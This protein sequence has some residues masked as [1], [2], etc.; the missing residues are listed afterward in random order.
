[1]YCTVLHI[2]GALYL[3]HK[4]FDSEKGLLKVLKK[5]NVPK[6][7]SDLNKIAQKNPQ[8]SKSTKKSPKKITQRS[9]FTKKTL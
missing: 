1:M 8:K 2:N 6:N 4:G 3:S 7:A 9:T 5:V